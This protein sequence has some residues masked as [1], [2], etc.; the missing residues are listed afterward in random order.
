[1]QISAKIVSNA[2][3]YVPPGLIILLDLVGGWF[4]VWND[5]KVA[6]LVS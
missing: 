2:A 1:M 6:G 5:S 3:E 4:I